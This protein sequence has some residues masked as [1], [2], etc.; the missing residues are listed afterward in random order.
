MDTTIQVALISAAA[1][2]I[3]AALAHVWTRRQQ[4]ADQL[5]ERKLERY[6]DLLSAISDLADLGQDQGLGR[7]TK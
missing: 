4:R 2:I 3:V 5:R 7:G 1:S 6:R